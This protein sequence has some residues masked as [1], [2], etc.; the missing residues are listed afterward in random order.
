MNN[1]RLLITTAIEHTW[2]KDQNFS[3]VFLTEACLLYSRKT[4]W[5]NFESEVVHYHWNNRKK[6]KEDHDYLKGLYEKVLIPVV[7][8]LNRLNNTIESVDYWRIIIGPWLI[9]YLSILFDRW[10]MIRIVFEGG[11]EITTADLPHQHQKIIARDFDDFSRIM[12]TDEWNFQVYH[13]IIKYR[14]RKLTNFH[15]F[16]EPTFQNLTK[17]NSHDYK[18]QIKH[19]TLVVADK[20]LKFVSGNPNIFIYRGYFSAISLARLNFSIGNIPRMYLEEFKFSFSESS[21]IEYRSGYTFSSKENDFEEYFMHTIFQDMPI[22]YLEAYK[23]IKKF[24][25]QIPIEPKKILTANAHWGED[26]FKYWLAL[27]KKRGKKIIISHH[28]GSIPPLF[29]TFSHEENIAVKVITWFK[30]YYKNHVQLPPNKLCGIVIPNNRGK[31]CSLIGFESPRFGYRATAGP[32]AN[33]VLDC[34]NQ[35]IKF[36]EALNFN[37][38]NL[39]KIRPYPDMGWQTKLRFEDKLG[40]EKIDISSHK[41]FIKNARLLVCTYPQT[42]FSEAMFSGKPVV[43]LYIPEF[44]ET[45]KVAT[46]LID[47]L[48]KA[49]IVF[50]DPIKAAEHINL[51]WDNLEEWWQTDE[52]VIARNIFYEYALN[53]DKGWLKKWADFLKSV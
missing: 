52:I 44:N 1:R 50:S 13:Q 17:Y 6:L 16:E 12:Q 45:F 41:A 47:I 27:Q 36:C 26:V 31:Y 9:T 29:D 53:I 35:N 38:K 32:I 48:V 10:E 19:N 43:L 2:Y 39:L 14:Y 37:I 3:R 4:E 34:F 11:E 49:K 5:Q 25:D 15:Q 7:E 51:H 30:P 40:K 46:E 8:N 18:Q 33:R 28:G 20:L 22:A 24:V 23:E 42:T 21:N